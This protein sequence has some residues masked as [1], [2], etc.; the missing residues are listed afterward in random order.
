[1]CGR[2][3][4]GLGKPNVIL[5]GAIYG[6]MRVQMNKSHWIKWTLL[7]RLCDIDFADDTSLITHTHHHMQEQ[8]DRLSSIAKITGVEINLGKTKKF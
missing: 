4:G 2:Q 3:Y 8:T 5:L 1:M 7:D 6:D